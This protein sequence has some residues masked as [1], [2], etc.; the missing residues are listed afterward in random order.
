MRKQVIEIG[1]EYT[2]KMCCCCGKI[3]AEMTVRDRVMQCECGTV[4]DHDRN[5]AVNI[6]LRY[7][8]MPCGRAT[9]GS[10]VI[11]DKQVSGSREVP[12]HSQ[13]APAQA[14][15]SSW[16]DEEQSRRG[17]FADGSVN[18]GNTIQ[19]CVPDV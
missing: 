9:G 4:L 19:M 10:P 16:R 7:H 14:G 1:E 17:R 15:G 12:G 3:H 8:R 13:E 5:A 2:S 18:P 11:C 6:M